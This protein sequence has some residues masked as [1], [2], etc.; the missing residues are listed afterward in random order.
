[1]IFLVNLPIGLIGFV[2]A[3]PNLSESRN[4]D[5]RRI[6]VPGQLLVIAGLTCLVMAIVESSSQGWTSPLILGLLVGAAV[7]LAVF[8]LVEARVREPL[9]PLQLFRT[10]LFSAANLVA[11][12]FGLT[13]I[14]PTFFLAQYFQQVQGYS[15]LGAGLRT[16]PMS[17]GAFLTA[18][19]AGRITG[20][21]GPRV[22]VA[23][24]GALCGGAV[25]LLMLLEPDSSY[26][27]VWWILGLMGIGFGLMFSPTIA[28]VF[29]VTPPNRAGLGSSTFN[30]SRQLGVTLGIAVFGTIVVQFFSSNMVSQLTQR[31][32]SSSLS[33]TIANRIAAA[34]ADAGN[35]S[36]PKHFPISPVALHQAINQA[37]VDAIHSSF[38]ISGIALLVSA[39]VVAFTFQRRVAAKKEAN[40]SQ[41]TAEAQAADTVNSEER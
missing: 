14:A 31:G 34:G 19:V 24:G 26:A 16:L 23:F 22:P 12:V 13:T 5:A 37:F 40:E 10:P 21:V 35:R 36:L 29:S 27:A 3:L 33:T 9:L 25:L 17:M 39:L 11:L 28:A 20:R 38:L 41:V 8:A 32:V 18:P 2:L 1:M 6:D 30:T 7:F 15:V 4:P